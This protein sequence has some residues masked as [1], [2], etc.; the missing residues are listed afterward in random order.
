MDPQIK[1]V[2][3]DMAGTTVR[4]ED[5]AVA[6][7]IR[8]ALREHGCTVTIGDVNPHIGTPKPQTIRTLLT[9]QR[10]EA[11]DDLVDTVHQRF[12]DLI[13]EHYRS[14][15]GVAEMVGASS[16]FA[17]LREAG[18][19]VTLDTGFDRLTLDTIVER[20]GWHGLLDDT[21]ASDEVRAGRPA[22]DMIETL[23]QR[24]GITDPAEV[25]KVGDSVSDMQQGIA[26]SCGL[27]I[28]VMCERTRDEYT[29]YPGVRPI[30]TLGE[31]GD[32]LGVSASVTP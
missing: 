22:P 19:K 30:E 17:A 26:A 5:N 29:K 23:M 4:D 27:V 9:Q 18:V 1:L 11:P 25:C 12:Q 13:V 20:L 6:N 2:V 31:L 16:L 32:M 8:T 3:F 24:S 28:A 21:V 10:G 7:A 15:P 14:A